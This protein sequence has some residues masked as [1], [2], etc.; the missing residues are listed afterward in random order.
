MS[1]IIIKEPELKKEVNEVTIKSYWLSI[2][3][4]RL[5]ASYHSKGV[6]RATELLEKSGYKLVSLE[7]STK[8]I[9]YLPRYKRYFAN[10]NVGEPYLMPSELFF[11]PFS[12]SKFVYA[13]KLKNLKDWYIKEGWIL[14][15]RSGKLGKI[16]ITTE[17]LEGFIISDDM[18]RI[19]PKANS[20][21][22]FLYAY[23]STW[24]GQA[25]LTKDEYGVAVNHIEPHHVKSIK[26]PILP[27]EIQELIH[28]NITKVFSLREKAR[29]LLAESKERLL[30][31]LDLPKFGTPSKTK[32]FST[33]SNNLNLRFDASYYN[34]TVKKVVKKLHD[35]K[36]KPKKL[37]KGIREPFFPNRFKRVYVNEEY[38][39]PFLSG[40]NIV[41]IKPYDL[42]FLSKRV[43]AELESCLVQKGWVLITRSGTVG[44]VALVPSYWD[45]WAITEHVMRLIPISKRLH[46]G[47]LTAFLLT[48]YGYVQ[49]KSKIY[50]GV[51]DE[52]AEDDVKDIVIPLPPMEVQEKIGK[53]VVEA[54]ALKELATKIEDETVKT[55]ENMLSSHKRM[56]LNEEYLKEI[57]A[58][59]DS[60]ELIGNEEFQESRR[61]LGS[62]ETTSFD[63]FKKEH[64]V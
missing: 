38:G 32:P 59:A 62:G 47:F 25:L 39:V 19:L 4:L 15:T 64:G 30:E 7:D 18:I 14:L 21:S 60:F 50:G 48:E 57:N 26:V 63:E 55:L 1:T 42:K 44:R 61:A 45:G 23:L 33:K 9:F 43:T 36:Y 16:T 11:F 24:I 46:E 41:Q 13:E 17:S 56:E 51:V 40:T 37:E 10:E 53:L 28:N 3:E 34:P 27:R 35:C 22:G 29:N 58:Y 49:V 2:G 8:E 31:E 20:C 52:L 12:P 5:D 54:F 6:S